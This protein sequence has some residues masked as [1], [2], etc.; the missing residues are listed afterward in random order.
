MWLYMRRLRRLH[1]NRKYRARDRYR[2][3]FAKYSSSTPL[4]KFRRRRMWMR[5]QNNRR[6]PD[7]PETG[8]GVAYTNERQ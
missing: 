1:F 5:E 3:V 6:V 7:A 4:P 2:T 8:Y